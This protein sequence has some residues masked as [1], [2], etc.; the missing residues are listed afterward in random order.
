ME[1][2]SKTDK[3]EPNIAKKKR[4]FKPELDKCLADE[5]QVPDLSEISQDEVKKQG[6]VVFNLD[7][8]KSSGEIEKIIGRLEIKYMKKSSLKKCRN[9]NYKKRSCLLDSSSCN[10]C[11]SKCMECNKSGHFPRSLNCKKRRKSKKTR[12]KT[13]KGFVKSSKKISQRIRKMIKP[14]LIC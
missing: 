3:I 8:G 1:E 4:K 13:I 7:L 2:K 9:C 10:A 6:D 11:K 12:S 5:M 14:R